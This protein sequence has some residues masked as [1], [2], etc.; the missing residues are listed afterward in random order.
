MLTTFQGGIHTLEP[1]YGELKQPTSAPGA[2][3]ASVD[4]LPAGSPPSRASKAVA[5]D[6][7]PGGVEDEGTDGKIIDADNHAGTAEARGRAYRGDGGRAEGTAP[8]H[9]AYRHSKLVDP[10]RSQASGVAGVSSSWAVAAE[11]AVTEG[12]H[13]A[14]GDSSNGLPRPQQQQERQAHSQER[15]RGTDRRFLKSS[16]S[17]KQEGTGAFRMPKSVENGVGG[18]WEEGAFGP[19]PECPSSPRVFQLGFAMDTG[20]F[21]VSPSSLSR[22]SFRRATYIR[23]H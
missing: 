8:T 9:V 23:S 11:A 17:G 15:R 19:Y 4:P 2:T 3:V 12:M 7:T 20:Y 14:A 13:L 1:V 21:K 5:A 10:I 22:S 18:T 6:E 16:P